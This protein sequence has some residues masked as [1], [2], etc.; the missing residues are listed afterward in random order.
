[1]EDPDAEGAQGLCRTMQAPLDRAQ[2]FPEKHSFKL[3]GVEKVDGEQLFRFEAENP[4]APVYWVL[5]SKN[6]PVIRRAVMKMKFGELEAAAEMVYTKLG[7][8]VEIP[9][10]HLLPPPRVAEE[11]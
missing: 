5:M 1:M 2:K 8:P 9:E 6:G 11:Q 4:Q 7:K 3:G 10:I